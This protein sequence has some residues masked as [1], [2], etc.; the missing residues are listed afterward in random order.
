MK[1]EKIKNILGIGLVIC[2]LLTLLLLGFPQ[3]FSS[4]SSAK[5]EKEKLLKF[6]FLKNETSKIVLLYA[7]YVGCK[8]I[9]VPSLQEL[10]HIYKK[11]AEKKD[12]S[13]YFVNL[14]DE[15]NEEQVKRFSSYFNNDFKG[16]YLSKKE[17]INIFNNL[18]INYSKSLSDKLE[19]N[20]SGYL[21]LLEKKEQNYY[22]KYIYTTRPFNEE[23]IINDL[24]TLLK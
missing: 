9:C 22:Q 7:G 24:K 18:N 4:N 20:H 21:Y 16:V 12:L 13:V 15:S 23:L 3:V 17:K 10:N 14:L 6:D 1:K 19:I 8:T 11:V 5:V 2:T